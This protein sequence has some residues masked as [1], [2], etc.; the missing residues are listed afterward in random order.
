MINFIKNISPTELIILAA[1]LLVLF[2]AKAFT[3]LG[4][5]AGESL[6]EVKNIKR[7]FNDAV[8]DKEPEKDKKEVSK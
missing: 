5:T 7:S 3:S 4:K 2:G 6:K 8:E 1:I